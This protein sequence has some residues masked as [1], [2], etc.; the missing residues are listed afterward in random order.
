MADTRQDTHRAVRPVD[1]EWQALVNEVAWLGACE[2]ERKALTLDHV[3]PVSWSGHRRGKHVAEQRSN[4]PCATCLPQE[5]ELT[6][7]S[8][9]RR[10]ITKL[11]R[12]SW[13]L[14]YEA[15]AAAFTA[16]ADALAFQLCTLTAHRCRFRPDSAA[17]PAST[18]AVGN[19]FRDGGPCCTGQRS[20]LH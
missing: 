10:S 15:V 2:A 12:L 13:S 18:S 14:T 19:L 11:T 8:G 1:G 7:C 3:A 6:E 16:A 5:G 4:G 20:L 17:D 9:L